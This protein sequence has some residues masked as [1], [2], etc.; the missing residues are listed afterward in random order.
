MK[1]EAAVADASSR[2]D[3]ATRVKQLLLE[4][5]DDTGEKGTD[6][7]SDLAI[8][9][10]NIPRADFVDMSR[11]MTLLNICSSFSI[12]CYF[13]GFL[14]DPTV[15]SIE[16]TLAA[17]KFG[18]ELYYHVFSSDL[19]VHHAAFAV[20]VFAVVHF[21]WGGEWC[22]LLILQQVIHLPLV[23]NNARHT[24]FLS[25][26][27]RILRGMYMLCWL[28]CATVRT[29]TLLYHTALAVVGAQVAAL[30][31][32][33]V[34]ITMAV[35]DVSWTPFGEYKSLWNGDA[36]AWEKVGWNDVGPFMCGVKL[37]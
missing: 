12:L 17:L 31:L 28:P 33:P 10:Y 16:C 14:S 26:Q 24:N 9:T 3:H 13:T 34:A 27:K 2:M 22:W 32:V 15:L 1:S 30:V 29:L 8:R 11:V 20:A 36:S 6:L 21:D 23:F 19:A 37:I 7:I 25:R 35:L 5:A 18:A 4:G